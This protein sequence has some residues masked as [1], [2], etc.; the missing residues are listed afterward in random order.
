ML[1]PHRLAVALC[2]CAGGIPGRILAGS[3]DPER[4]SV[5]DLSLRGTAGWRDTFRWLGSG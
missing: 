3:A 5:S 4:A 1:S 2:L